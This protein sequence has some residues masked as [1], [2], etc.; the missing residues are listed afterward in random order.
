MGKGGAPAAGNGRVAM[1]LLRPGAPAAA[2]DAPERPAQVDRPVTAILVFLLASLILSGMAGMSKAVAARLAPEQIIL[3][4]FLIVSCAL[5]AVLA[6]RR[7]TLSL[8]TRMPLTH[9]LRGVML[10]ASATIHVVALQHLPLAE[11]TAISFS[12][13]LYVTAMSVPLLR[14]TVGIRRWAAVVLGFA[15]VLI[16]LRP[17]T[18][19]FQPAALL[20]LLSS[21][22]WAACLIIT[23]RMR[24]S[25]PPLTVLGWSTLVGTVAVAPLGI[26]SWRPPDAADWALLTAIAACFLVGQYLTIRAFMIASAS[27]LAPF[28]Y[29]NLIWATLIGAV[30]F[31]SLPDLATTLGAAVLVA[32]GLYVWHRERRRAVKATVPEGTVATT[33]EAVVPDREARR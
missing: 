16:I 33:A 11:A 2:G 26:A 29:A 15:G 23:R 19:L 27:L 31:A 13:P 3:V 14:E 30:F 6:V 25:E 5:V 7:R 18:A 32:A 10:V 9:V 28:T 17:G 24:G 20:P 8:A 4:R 22:L 12:T 1:T 21:F